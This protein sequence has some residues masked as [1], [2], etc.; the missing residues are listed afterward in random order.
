MP[1]PIHNYATDS[2]VDLIKNMIDAVRRD[3]A[4]GK[5]RLPSDAMMFF[6]TPT[7]EPPATDTPEPTATDTPVPTDTP[8]VEPVR[9]TI[10]LPAL[11]RLP[12]VS[13]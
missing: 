6:D 3:F 5:A 10:Y 12:D 13:G 7:P 8:T 9:P 2:G 1:E 4:E 11:Y